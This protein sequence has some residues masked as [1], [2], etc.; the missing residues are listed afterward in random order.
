MK[1]LRAAWEV[2]LSRHFGSE[3]FDK[4]FERIREKSIQNSKK[5]ESSTRDRSQLFVAL[6]RK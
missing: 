4:V 3:I 2:K 1:H 6:K 5:I